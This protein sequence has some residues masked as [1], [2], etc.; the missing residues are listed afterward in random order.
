VDAAQ[1]D[2]SIVLDRASTDGAA[3]DGV[4]GEN[5]L[6]GGYVLI[7]PAANHAC[8]RMIVRNSATIAGSTREITLDLDMPI[9]EALTADS[10]L[11]E[12]MASPYLKV[13]TAVS[14]LRSVVCIPEVR[15]TDGQWFWGKKDGVAWAAPSAGA[16]AG[17]SDRSVC[18]RYNGSID[19]VATTGYGSIQ[20][21]HAGTVLTN[22]YAGGQGAPF[23]ILHI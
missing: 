14:E 5:E 11:A 13:V 10:A 8:V 16:G 17:N 4:I 15:A 18:F 22:A 2:T 12:A 1:Y 21:Q 6:Q 20:A 19:E 23:F 3:H 7:F 9:P